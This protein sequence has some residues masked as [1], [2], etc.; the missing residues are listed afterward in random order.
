MKT[1]I[2]VVMALAASLLALGQANAG[3]K[4]L[5]KHQVPKPVLE[6]FEKAY[7]NVKGVEFEKEMLEGKPAYEVE[8]KENGKEYEVVYDADGSLLQKEEGIDLQALPEPVRQAVTK[9]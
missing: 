9:A 2:L 4:K 7:P 3:E 1:Q 5:S 8:Y 6:A